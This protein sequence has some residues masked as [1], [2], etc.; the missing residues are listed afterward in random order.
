MW[1]EKEVAFLFLDSIRD[2]NE[3]TVAI[4]GLFIVCDCQKLFL[5]FHVEALDGGLSFIARLMLIA[6]RFLI[7]NDIRHDIPH[8]ASNR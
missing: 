2:G 6:H 3:A 4:E 1:L 8:G 7:A 5:G